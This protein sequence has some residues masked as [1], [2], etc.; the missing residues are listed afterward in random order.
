MAKEKPTL[1]RLSKQLDN[2]RRHYAAG[3]PTTARALLERFKDGAKEVHEDQQENMVRD[4]NYHL[5]LR[6]Q[7]KDL[8]TQAKELAAEVK[9]GDDETPE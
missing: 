8:T 1:F 2:A 3:D 9:G 5:H 7:L 4:M 6:Q